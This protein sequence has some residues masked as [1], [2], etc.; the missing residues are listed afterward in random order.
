[1]V[2]FAARNCFL[3]AG[4]SRILPIRQGR[5]LLSVGNVRDR[6]FDIGFDQQVF[7]DLFNR[8]KA[9]LQGPIQPHETCTADQRKR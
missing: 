4:E 6:F 1:M 5:A 8:G 3:R 9:Q 2:S 7:P